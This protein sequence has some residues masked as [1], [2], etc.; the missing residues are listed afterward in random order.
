MSDNMLK[1]LFD[2]LP[3][4]YREDP[5]LGSFLQPY[6]AVF[7]RFEKLLAEIDRTFIPLNRIDPVYEADR[8]FLPWLAGWLAL[9]LDEEWDEE[10]SREVVSRVV[11]LYR[12]RGTVKGLKE[13]LKIYT[14]HLPEIRE[15]SWPAGMQIGVSSMIGGCEP[16]AGF[17]SFSAER[18]GLIWRDW[19][20]VAEASAGEYLYWSDCVER[21]DPDLDARRVTVFHKQPGDYAATMTVH[22]NA[23]VTRW[24]G[25]SDTMYDLAGIPFDGGEAIT[26]IYA[27]D[28]VL[29][30]DEDDIPYR[31]IVDVTV[32]VATLEKVRIEKIKGIIDLEKP[33]HTLYY[34]RLNTQDRRGALVPMQLEIRSTIETNTVL[35]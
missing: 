2:H 26:G 20:V 30:E 3:A 17:S 24:D 9:E 7:G 18:R 13:Y 28:S 21:V 31:F 5:W 22:D 33:A 27:G 10:K 35:G 4:L 32:P 14:G 29:V 34:L 11:E 23:T 15:C 12:L 25:I 16:L 1:L 6:A 19:Y 8:E